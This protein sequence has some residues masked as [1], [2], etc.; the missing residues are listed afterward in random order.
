MRFGPRA[1]LLIRFYVGVGW[2]VLGVVSIFSHPTYPSS[3]QRSSPFFWLEMGGAVAVT[4]AVILGFALR[5]LRRRREK[6]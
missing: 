6:S 1:N 3:D 2:V 4:G 5:D